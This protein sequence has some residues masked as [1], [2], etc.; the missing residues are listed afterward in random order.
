MSLAACASLRNRHRGPSW[1][2]KSRRNDFRSAL[3]SSERQVRATCES[4]L[5]PRPARDISST[6]RWSSSCVRAFGPVRPSCRCGFPG[7]AELGA[8]HPYA[9]HDHGPS[10]SPAVTTACFS[11]R[12][13]AISMA[14]ALSRTISFGAIDGRSLGHSPSTVSREISRNGG[15]DRYRAALADDQAW[16]RSRRPKRCKLADSPRLRQAV[17]RKLR[18]SWS[19]EQIAG[20]LKRARS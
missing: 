7:P 3:P 9:V 19:P 5:I 4:H 14:R 20:W 13:L 18:L 6:A 17:A 12:R 10:A 8:V 1:D 15:Y 11:P 16:A 2:S